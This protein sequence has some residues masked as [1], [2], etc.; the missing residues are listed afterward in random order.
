MFSKKIFIFEIS[1][2]PE[3]SKLPEISIISVILEYLSSLSSYLM[4]PAS[5]LFTEAGTLF[6]S[7]W[8]NPIVFSY[9]L[10]S[11]KI[12]SEI[13]S[14]F[15]YFS[16][17]YLFSIVSAV[18]IFTLYFFFIILVFSGLTSYNW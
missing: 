2:S 12:I 4:L 11:N 10:L 3:V 16:T 6:S 8:S 9:P 17:S 14:N 5:I 7:W 18:I 13:E 15:L 1:F